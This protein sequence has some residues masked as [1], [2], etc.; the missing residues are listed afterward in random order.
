MT[1]FP[2]LTFTLRVVKESC[3]MHLSVLTYTFDQYEQRNYPVFQ[4][5]SKG[6]K[7][8]KG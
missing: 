1:E 8:G 7:D 2:L 6:G 3:I 5:N 4:H